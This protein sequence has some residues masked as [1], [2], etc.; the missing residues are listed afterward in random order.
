MGWRRARAEASAVVVPRDVEALEAV[1][2]ALSADLDSELSVQEAIAKTLLERLD[3]SY[4]GVWLPE[5]GGVNLRL[6][7]GDLAERVP[8]TTAGL[9]IDDPQA[10]R[11]VM[12]MTDPM[13][14]PSPI[15]SPAGAARC[16]AFADVGAPYGAYLPLVAGGVLVAMHEYRADRPL[17]FFEGREGKWG[18]LMRLAATVSRSTLHAASLRET[19]E[20]RRAV[21]EVVARINAASTADE[22][23]DLALET[24]RS[25]FGWAYSSFWALDE[26]AGVLRFA[27]ESGTAGQEFRDVTLAASFAEGV[28][29][30]GRAWKARDVVFVEDLGELTDCVRAPAAQ[31]AGVRSGICFPITLAGQVVGTMDFFATTTL[32][33]SE[34][35][36]QSLRQVQQLVI[37]R[38]EVIARAEAD[39]AGARDLLDTV[40]R[41]REAAADAAAV[42]QRAVVGTTAVTH[43]VTALSA[44]STA[45][46]DIIK[47]ISSIAEQTNLLA[48]N[49]TI[50]AARAGE[51]GKGF[52]VVAGEVKEL[53]RATA[54]ATSDVTSRIADIQTNSTAVAAGISDTAQTI[55]ELDAVQTRISD[56]L[57]EQDH[58]ARA[59]TGR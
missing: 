51:A 49:A 37:Q 24:V 25:A 13:S 4:A 58:M 11:A 50:E 30:S 53:A 59:F 18:A 2:G 12:A 41:L 17:P 54:Q 20:D 27:Q 47:V 3:L 33:M 21:T 29:L 43:E 57:T 36:L 32:T 8:S 10:V 14:M 22:A 7:L 52:A 39:Q 46:G 15:N 55:S 38:L 16:A 34:S 1:L 26:G 31:R 28:G 45:I 44:S 35:R 42:G 23:L 5:R 56:V 19:L 6:S 40:A 9:R 48:L